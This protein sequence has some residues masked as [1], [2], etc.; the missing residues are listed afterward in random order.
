MAAV[1]MVRAMRSPRPRRW[2]RR[3]DDN[4]PFES[5]DKFRVNANGKKIDVWLIFACQG[6]G[7]RW[8]HR[9]V[10]RRTVPQIGEDRYR[11]YL[12]NDV[13]LARAEAFAMAGKDARRVPFEV[14][15]SGDGPSAEIEIHLEEPIDLRVDQLLAVGLGVSRG[16]LRRHL[17]RALLRKRVQHRDRIR[18]P[19]GLQ[20]GPEHGHGGFGREVEGGAN[21]GADGPSEERGAD[22][23]VRIGWPDPS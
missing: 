15:R 7:A 17:D 1:W 22:R 13:A 10:Q 8:N 23:R 12:D 4:Q 21:G 19:A 5:T 2:C 16:T 9:L 18:L 11:R 3:C 6:C 14:E 20:L